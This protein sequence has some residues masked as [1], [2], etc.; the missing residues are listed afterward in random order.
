M[1]C[2]PEELG[3]IRSAQCRSR[4][5][6]VVLRVVDRG[7]RLPC[8]LRMHRRIG[9]IYSPITLTALTPLYLHTCRCNVQPA[10]VKTPRQTSTPYIAYTP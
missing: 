8:T 6:S 4:V 10:E 3:Q 9:G 2:T 1:T 5:T 7:I